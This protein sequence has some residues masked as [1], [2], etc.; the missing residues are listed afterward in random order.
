MSLRPLDRRVASHHKSAGAELSV[1]ARAQGAKTIE[2]YDRANAT[3]P[4]VGVLMALMGVRTVGD[5]V[6]V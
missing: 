4:P 6:Q 1:A 5:A 2:Q 3:N